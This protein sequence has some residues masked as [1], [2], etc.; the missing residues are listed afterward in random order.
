MFEIIDRA[1]EI[2]RH[3]VLVMKRLKFSL[4]VGKNI[5]LN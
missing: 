2:T 4:K 3:E 1:D 5:K